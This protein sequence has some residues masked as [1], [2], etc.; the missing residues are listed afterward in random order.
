[1]IDVLLLIL[2]LGCIV[3]MWLFVICIILSTGADD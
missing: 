2:G 3:V 1:V